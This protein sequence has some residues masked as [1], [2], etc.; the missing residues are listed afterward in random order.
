[1]A[2]D[3]EAVRAAFLAWI[4]DD[5]YLVPSAVTDIEWD[6]EG[7]PVYYTRTD[8]VRHYLDGE[9]HA[10]QA[11]TSRA[12]LAV[13]PAT[14]QPGACVAPAPDNAPRVI[15]EPDGA[16]CWRVWL[17]I[18]AGAWAVGDFR[19][20]KEAAERFA[21]PLRRALLAA[22]P[23]GGD[24]VKEAMTELGFAPAP[25]TGDAAAVGIAGL[26]FHVPRDRT[27]SGYT[28]V[29]A[30]MGNGHVVVMGSP[31]DESHS[32]D[33]LGC[34]STGAHVIARLP[35]PAPATAVEEARGA[36]SS[37]AFARRVL[38]ATLLDHDEIVCG[39]WRIECELDPANLTERFAF[40]TPKGETMYDTAEEAVDA[41]LA[42]EAA[43]EG[44]ALAAKESRS[45]DRP[46]SGQGGV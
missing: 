32:C 9:W 30:Y 17:H 44:S 45:D 31:I 21:E 42:A 37:L 33:A 6:D 38:V 19:H 4:R 10:W 12:A 16:S 1:V 25:A 28:R 43:D 8:G 40:S 11:A 26:D 27:P 14:A 13:A 23:G 2:N 29:E 39:D 15:V 7:L 20:D 24:V 22:I 18:N 46:A 3:I 41:L 36:V 34:G 5:G 35:L